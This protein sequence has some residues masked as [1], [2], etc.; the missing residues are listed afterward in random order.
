[1]IKAITAVLFL[2]LSTISFALPSLVVKSVCKNSTTV[3]EFIA[4]DTTMR[5]TRTYRT[6][7]SIKL[8]E[9]SG[10]PTV[11]VNEYRVQQYVERDGF[12]IFMFNDVNEGVKVAGNWTISEDGRVHVEQ[13]VLGKSGLLLGAFNEKYDGCSY[14]RIK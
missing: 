7:E 13:A 12:I 14:S 10:F 2:S 4:S 3:D 6:P 5:M 8:L 9:R 11:E 1:M